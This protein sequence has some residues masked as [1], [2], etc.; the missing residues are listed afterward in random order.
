MAFD[1]EE[2]KAHL[3]EH[4]WARVPSV[5]TKEE[6]AQALDRL[7]KAKEAAEARGEETYLSFLD[8][9]PSNVRVFYLMELDKIFRDMISRK[10]LGHTSVRDGPSTPLT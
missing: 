1:L 5:L 10:R 4:G 8:P 2:A 7:W 9:N 3:K 6:A